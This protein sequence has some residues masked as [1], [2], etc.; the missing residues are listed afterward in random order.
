[1]K[2]IMK[3]LVTTS[4]VLMISFMSVISGYSQSLW[5]SAKSN[6]D[7]LTIS[8]LFIAQ[9]VRDFLS[10]PAGLDKA[11]NWC[12][13]TGLTRVFIETFRGG[14][15]AD[16][17]VLM[18][19]KKRF[20]NEGFDVSGCVTTVNVGKNGTGGWGATACYTN[21]GTLEELQKIF[22][23]TASIFDIIMIDDFLFTECECEDCMAARG[24]MPWSKFR[25]DLMVNV[26]RERI[27]KPAR[28]VNPNAKIIIKYP[29][30]YDSFQERGY[31]VV[32]ESKDYDFTWVGTETRDYDYNVRPGGEVQYNAFFITRWMNS[33][34]GTKNLGG[35]VDAL[36][37]TPKIYLEQARQTV[38]G[39]GKEVMLFHYGDL[40]NEKNFYDEKPGTPTADIA[41]FR[42]ELPGLFNLARLVN[43]K[44]LSGIHMPK[45]P[46]SEPFNEQYIF[47]FLGMLGLPLVPA[48]AID[49]KAESAIFTVHSLKEPGFSGK[50]KH[51]MEAGT[52]VIITDGLAER[53]SNQALLSDKNLTV[54]KTGGD[55]K[56]L[57]KLT[58]EELKPL[59]DKLLAPLGMKFDAPNKVSFYL[60]GKDHF[61]VENFNDEKVDVTIEFPIL[62][63]IKK[64][65]SL[66]EEGSG[67]LSQDK[68]SVTI[69]GL[70]PRTLLVYEYR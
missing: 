25:S 47:S 13:E 30:W 39:N 29:L 68:N 43:G 35:W 12:K 1:M 4:I 63:A 58:R 23:F 26:S 33:I 5:E 41:A 57:L 11:V 56:N 37:T 20:L 44:P 38:V 31:E 17:A 21:K 24:D 7:V 49:E 60:L 65:L 52:P 14:Y 8:T 36:G 69:K 32:R 64:V 15:Y 16:R 61:I 50:L 46:N 19:A 66:P 67:V 18:N 55:P 28:K 62:S 40:Q 9:D 34:S 45:L 2:K 22:E 3:K 51:I 27:L 48:S 54:L 42:K 10:T 70:S 59:R 53:L 6:R